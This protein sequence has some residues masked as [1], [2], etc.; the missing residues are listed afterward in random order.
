M[1]THKL[2]HTGILF[3]RKKKDILLFVTTWM[4]LEGLMLSE[5]S[6]AEKDKCDFLS[7]IQDKVIETEIRFLVARGGGWRRWGDWV[8][9]VKRRGA[10]GAQLVKHLPSLRS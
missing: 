7:G 2:T 9:V 1:Q 4:D 5:I 6:Q 10:W 8:K 3:S